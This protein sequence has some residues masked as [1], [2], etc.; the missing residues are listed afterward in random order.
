MVNPLEPEAAVESEFV[1]AEPE[2]DPWPHPVRASAAIDAPARMVDKRFF[3]D[4]P[5]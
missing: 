2:G 3:M 4:T 5:W 1:A